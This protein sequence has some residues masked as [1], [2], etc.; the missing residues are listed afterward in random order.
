M[1]ASPVW[2]QDSSRQAVPRPSSAAAI[3]ASSILL[4]ATPSLALAHSE[5]ADV[6][7]GIIDPL[8]THHA[9]LEDELKVNYD[10]ARLDENG[11][12]RHVGSL[13]LAVAL[14]D[15]WGVEVFLPFGVA[16]TPSDA[17]RGLGDLELQLPKWSPVRRHGLILTTYTAVRAPTAT[18][19][20][21]LG[22]PGWTIA[23]HVLTDLGLGRWGLQLN[24]AVEVETEGHVALEGKGSLAWSHFLDGAQTWRISPLAEVAVEAPVGDG[25]EAPELLMTVGVKLGYGGWHLGLGT[26]PPL[27]DAGAEGSWLI[28]QLGYHVT[29]EEMFRRAGRRG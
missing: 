8:V 4:W 25:D 18:P 15:A 22:E 1:I 24:G 12:Q 14:T 7:P 26:Q 16:A 13:E 11:V 2:L 20:A 21:D 5:H 28:A 6:A 19:G 10:A 27:T 23:P 29:W 9:V 3:L 17:V